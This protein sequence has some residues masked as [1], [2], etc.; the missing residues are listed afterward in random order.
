MTQTKFADTPFENGSEV[1]KSSTDKLA[2]II[3]FWV[4]LAL[5]V[6]TTVLSLMVV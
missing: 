1:S 6:A 2:S 4:L 3:W 5:M